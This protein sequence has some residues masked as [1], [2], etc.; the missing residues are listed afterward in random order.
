MT[1]EAYVVYYTS[2]FDS[3]SHRLN[4]GDATSTNGGS[5]WTAHRLTTVSIEPDA[6]PN[7]YD[8]LAPFG[9]GGSFIVPQL[10]DYLQATARNGNLYV[11][12][13]GTYQAEL[14]TLQTDPFLFVG[15]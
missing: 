8:D 14:G 5:T 2:R 11:L 13:S 6:D 3:Y 7:Y 4:V 12:F 10:G 9:E 1:G 15:T